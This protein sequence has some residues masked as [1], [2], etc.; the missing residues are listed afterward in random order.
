MKLVVVTGCL[1][2]IGTHVTR[3]CLQKGW[4]V[5]GVD[6]CTYVSNIHLLKE[7]ENNPNFTFIRKDICDL[8]GLP[9]CDYVINLAAE[10]HVGNSIID[11]GEF[12][13]SNIMGVKRILDI[14]RAKPDNVGERP[15]LIHF[16]T[17][18]VYGDIVE[19]EHFETDLLHPS[20]P[21]S[22]AKAAADM[23]IFAW[24]RTYG[25]PYNIL[26]PT[27]NYG[28][29]QYH[30][31]LIPISVRCLQRG[32]KIRLH[33][34]GEPIRTW[35]HADDTAEAVISVIEKGTRNEIYN[36][37]GG[38]EQKNKDTVRQIIEN[39]YGPQIDWNAY[40]D[41]GYRRKGQDVRYSVNDQKIRDL[42]WNPIK[43]FSEE[44]P[45]IVKSYK[46]NFRW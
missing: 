26:R 19:G 29:H 13:S 43:V 21:Y 42:G 45:K 15:V 32:K 37:S 1:G 22:A 3:K 36:I 38:F 24:G 34:E 33:D 17:D 4:R 23:L 14:I 8:N 18:E 20:N 16:S 25:I 40:V 27:N 41:F 35:L 6:K 2:F 44:I 7:F 39:F 10:S 9:D 5:L 30:E 28:E 12:I 31:K 46:N 11:S